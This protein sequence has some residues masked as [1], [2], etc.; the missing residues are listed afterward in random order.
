MKSPR[1]KV[2]SPKAVFTPA[3]V[4]SSLKDPQIDLTKFSFGPTPKKEAK[5]QTGSDAKYKAELED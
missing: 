1:A 4:I 3:S 2:K 5:K